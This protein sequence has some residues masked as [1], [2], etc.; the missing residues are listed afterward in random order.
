MTT[1][2]P[3]PL[4][5]DAA[6]NFDKI[7]RA[8]RE[9]YAERGPEA[10]LDEIAR[11]AGVGNATLYRHFPDKTVLV[12]AALDQAFAEEIAPAIEQALSDDDPR[13]GLVTVLEA[14]L[15]MAA[16]EHNTLAAARNAGAM[17]A[18]AGTRSLESLTLLAR[19]AQQAGLI[20]ADLVPDDLPRIVVMLLGLL[21]TMDPQ[22]D[23]WRRYLSLILDALAPDAATP[24]PAAV[25]LQQPDNWLL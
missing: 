25:P 6:R 22:S 10:Q 12:R 18:E 3:K 2:A 7:V 19:R 9:I 8:A 20:R 16:R 14:T 13:R 1:E 11:H 17:T 23:G 5:A 24:L 21:W 4:R 15:S